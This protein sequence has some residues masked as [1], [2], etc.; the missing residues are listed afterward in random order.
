MLSDGD[1]VIGWSPAD[2]AEASVKEPPADVIGSADRD[3]GGWQIQLCAEAGGR[4]DAINFL[5]VAGKSAAER[6]CIPNPPVGVNGVDLYFPSDDGPMAFDIRPLPCVDTRWEFVVACAP[7]ST[8]RISFP[9]LSGLPADRIATLRDL[10]T[11]AVVALRTAPSYEYTAD[12]QRRFALDITRRGAGSA[13]ITG[14]SAMQ[15]GQGAAIT[16][17][18]A[19]DAQM[20]LEVRS[21]SGVPIR[22]LDC[23]SRAAGVNTLTWDLCGSSGTRVPSGVYLCTITA[24]A[25]DGSRAS[26]VRTVTVR[27]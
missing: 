8:V 23:G 13:L 9:D 25:A 6:L 20:R 17:V 11:G 14:V 18:L 3:D 5:G 2:V 27:R 15:L 22:R 12:G 24:L 19:E 1:G 26:T 7:G 10:A 4:S 16:C 21:I